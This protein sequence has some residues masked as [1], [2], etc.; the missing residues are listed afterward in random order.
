MVSNDNK[1]RISTFQAPYCS[2]D[3]EMKAFF[4]KVVQEKEKKLNSKSLI[5]N[6]YMAFFHVTK[7]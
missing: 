7:N 4:T 3:E 6:Y 1:M 2:A 5:L